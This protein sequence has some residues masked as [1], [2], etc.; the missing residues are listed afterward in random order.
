MQRFFISLLFFI[1]IN[2]IAQTELQSD[3][4]KTTKGDL[5]IS[6][7]GHGSLFFEF[8]NLVVHVDPVRRYSDYS[9][10]PKADL[11]LIT[12]HHG[13]HLDAKAVDLIIKEN[14]ILY[15]NEESIPNVPSGKVL[16]NGDKITFK[17]IEVETVPAYNIIN[18]REN[19]EPFHPKGMGNGYVVTF[20]T[21][22][23]YIAGDTENI[24]EMKNLK[25]IEIAFLPMN[26]PYTMTPAMVADAV[27]MFNPK[28]L[29]PYH[30][31]NT[32]VNELVDL[33]KDKKDCEIRIRKMN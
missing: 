33:L 29:Y 18:K 30:F 9:K 6:F 26:L 20:D 19:G 17:G 5:K 15:C 3:I 11:I 2:L 23:V 16:K 31:G 14:T 12:H 24:L 13:D 8:N 4:I 27:N 25:G 21:K 32:N 7:V 1:S 28:I 22:K 10:L